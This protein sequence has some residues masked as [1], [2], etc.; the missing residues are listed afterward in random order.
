MVQTGSIVFNVYTYSTTGPVL[1]GTL[2]K[3]GADPGFSER[4]SEYL[5]EPVW[6]EAQKL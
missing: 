5:K 6:V 4:G 2:L 3:A 1:Y